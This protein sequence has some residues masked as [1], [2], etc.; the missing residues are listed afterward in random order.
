MSE[1]NSCSDELDERGTGSCLDL[2]LLA[3]EKVGEFARRAD[4]GADRG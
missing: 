4:L 3:Y 2:S 1:T